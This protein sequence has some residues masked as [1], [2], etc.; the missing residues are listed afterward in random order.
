M[1]KLFLAFT[2]IPTLELYLLV[3]VGARIGAL[4]TI[5]VVL[6]TGF[7]GAWL[8][9]LE[10]LSTLNRIREAL[11]AGEVPTNELVEGV[12]ILV[13]GVVLITPGFL[14]DL[15]GLTLLF[16]LTR[17]P[18]REWVKSKLEARMAVRSTPYGETINHEDVRNHH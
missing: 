2:V 5:A 15:A 18:I 13:A 12:L 17:Y 10:G 6:G 11:Q 14:T 7:L 4:A 9:K 8:A 16:P 3:Q 1:L